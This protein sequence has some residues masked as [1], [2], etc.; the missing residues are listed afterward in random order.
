MLIIERNQC[1]QT[2]IMW[3]KLSWQYQNL[4]WDDQSIEREPQ[5]LVC[6][7]TQMFCNLPTHRVEEFSGPGL[8]RVPW[9]CL[10]C[11]LFTANLLDQ[12][13]FNQHFL[14]MET[15]LLPPTFTSTSTFLGTTCWFS[16]KLI[17]TSLTRP[18]LHWLQGRTLATVLFNI[19]KFNC[20]FRFQSTECKEWGRWMNYDRIH[21]KCL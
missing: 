17:N 13:H 3:I 21:N 19:S 6:K 15:F 10:H 2:R 9:H 4:I 12:S 7:Q 1:N 18:W 8:P 11:S 5:K 20:Q 14:G 16:L